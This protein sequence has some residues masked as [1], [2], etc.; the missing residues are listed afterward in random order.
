MYHCVRCHDTERSWISFHH[1][2]FNGSHTSSD[3]KIVIFMNGAIRFQEV[4]LQIYF[5]QIS[6]EIKTKRLVL[7]LKS[8]KLNFIK[9]SIN[10][11]FAPITLFL[12]DYS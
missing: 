6:V 4:G 8:I 3:N 11:N 5:K 7:Y 9:N 1:F 10:F 2:E 12:I